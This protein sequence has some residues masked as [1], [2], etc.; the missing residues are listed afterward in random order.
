MRHDFPVLPT[1][2]RRCHGPNEGG[3][4]CVV[5][6]RD[7]RTRA[8]R[9]HGSWFAIGW[10][11]SPRM[12]VTPC[13]RR[14]PRPSSSEPAPVNPSERPTAPTRKFSPPPLKSVCREPRISQLGLCRLWLV[15]RRRLLRLRLRVTR[16][17]GSY[18]DR[19][20]G[21]RVR[22]FPPEVDHLCHE[23]SPFRFLVL[24]RRA[25]SSC[26]RGRARLAGAERLS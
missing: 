19:E 9:R 7:R 4:R 26:H 13:V 15:G 16:G 6:H 5:C 21:V 3:L 14:S 1:L 18:V 20:R 17:L 25:A 2:S 12:C 22:F 8:F 11:A 24:P 23:T 10:L